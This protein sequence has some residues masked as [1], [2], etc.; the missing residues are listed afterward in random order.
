MWT[1]IGIIIVHVIII[2]IEVPPLLRN[3]E[4]KELIG[5][6]ILLFIG[7]VLSILESTTIELPNPLDLVTFIYKPVSDFVYGFLK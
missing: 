4:R 3:S 2:W 6:S 5:F 1:I 7:F